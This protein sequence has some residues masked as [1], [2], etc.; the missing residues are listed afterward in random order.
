[1]KIL[2][3]GDSIT[4]AG[5]NKNEDY[6]I[7]SYGYGY[8]Y[9]I[10]AALTGRRPNEYDIINRGVDGN[11]IVDLY[12][13][14]KGDVWNLKP[15]ML[16][17]LIGI[18]DIWH[19]IGWNNGV[20]IIRWEKIYRMIIEDTLKVLTN[21]KIVIM[22]PF[23]LK[24]T[25]TEADFDRFSEVKKYASV[26]KRIAEDYNCIFVPLQKELDTASARNGESY[27]LSDG[28][29]PAIG[30]AYI[31]ADRWLKIVLNERL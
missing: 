22:E 29:H 8:P 25:A 11:R 31:I 19:E 20:D 15:D 28:V 14:I 16:S 5:R 17:V 4:D 6:A 7:S 12:S 13:R 2:F 10:T 27:C 1:M 21:I 18:N 23:V 3:Y 9:M 24:G 26:A 30:G